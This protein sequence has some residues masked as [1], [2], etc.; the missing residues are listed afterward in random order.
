MGITYQVDKGNGYRDVEPD[1][2]GV[3][4]PDC[5]DPYCDGCWL[6]DG[7][8]PEPWFQRPQ[9]RTAPVSEARRPQLRTTGIQS[10]P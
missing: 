1:G 7:P 6:P 9:S 2:S 3:H 10:F 5:T 8:D 4:Q